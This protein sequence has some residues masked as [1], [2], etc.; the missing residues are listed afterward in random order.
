MQRI[1]RAYNGHYPATHSDRTR[2]PSVRASTWPDRCDKL[3]N[4][5]SYRCKRAKLNSCLARMSQVPRRMEENYRLRGLG[6]RG[7]R[8]YRGELSLRGGRVNYGRMNGLI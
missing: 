5:R 1:Q 4:E 7:T 6:E 2:T 8:K 3:S